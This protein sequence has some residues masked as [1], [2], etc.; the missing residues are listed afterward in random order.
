MIF[1]VEY[2]CMMYIGTVAGIVTSYLDAF[3]IDILCFEHA[4]IC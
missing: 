4:R 3:Q 1:D 2:L